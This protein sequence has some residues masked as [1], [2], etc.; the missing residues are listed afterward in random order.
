MIGAVKA[1]GSVASSI[2]FYI[3]G[4]FVKRHGELSAIIS[5]SLFTRA[6]NMIAFSFP[7]LASPLLI[8][9]NSPAFGINLVA[10]N[11]LLQKEFSPNQ[12]ATMGSINS[13][14]GNLFFAIAA[15]LFG[16][17]ADALSPA[18]ALLLLQVILLPV[19]LVYLRLKPQKL[20]H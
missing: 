7:S 5:T 6:T 9:A 17:A 13:V 4:R 16:M 8:I 14:A 11:S 19:M 15:P 20:T 12:R 2:G 18:R 3:S 10:K 1:V